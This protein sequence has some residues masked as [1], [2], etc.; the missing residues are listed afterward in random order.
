MLFDLFHC[1][2]RS[3]QRPYS[4]YMYARNLPDYVMTVNILVLMNCIRFSYMTNHSKTCCQFLI[5][6]ELEMIKL[7]VNNADLCEREREREKM[8]ALQNSHKLKSNF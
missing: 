5:D 4:Y 3:I 8:K 2:I 1:K 7:M 6:S